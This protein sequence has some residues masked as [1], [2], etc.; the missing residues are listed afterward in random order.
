MIKKV[1][2]VV[3]TRLAKSKEGLEISNLFFF[4][5]KK[6]KYIYNKE[7]NECSFSLREVST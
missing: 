7:K 2:P 1:K 3:M 4:V 5:F 6:T